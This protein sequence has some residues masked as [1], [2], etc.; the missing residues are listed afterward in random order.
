MLRKSDKTLKQE[1]M[2]ELAWDSDVEWPAL[3]DVH[4]SAED[5]VVTLTGSVSTYAGK[6]AAQ[7]AALDV[8]GVRGVTNRLEVKLDRIR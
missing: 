3:S 5:G 7:Q 6:L 2:D 4:V 1:V 8:A